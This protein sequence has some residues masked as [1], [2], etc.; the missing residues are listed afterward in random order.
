MIPVDQIMLQIRR[1]PINQQKILHLAI[2]HIAEE[3]A[4]KKLKSLK[5][6]EVIQMA[7]DLEMTVIEA[8]EVLASLNH[9]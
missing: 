6:E 7:K 4:I 1:L 2:S 9:T 3:E 8:K 5:E